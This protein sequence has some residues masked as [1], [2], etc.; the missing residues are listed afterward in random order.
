MKT[1]KLRR[2][3]YRLLSIPVSALA[4]ALAHFLKT[5]NPMMILIIPVVFFAF[6]DGYIGGAL[7]GI[8]SIL[9]SM[10][11]F[12]NTDQL[13]TYNEINIQ[14][15]MTIVVAVLVIVLLVGKLK[16][17]DEKA[18]LE[19]EELLTELE[20]MNE[21]LDY[22]VLAA[23]KANTAKSEFLARMSHDIRTPMNV[24]L[25]MTDFAIEEI[26]NQDAVLSYL[27][28]INNSG[29]FLL[30]LINDVLDISKI[31]SGELVLNY[32][33]YNLQDFVTEIEDMFRPMC[34]AKDI[35]FQ[36]NTA[37]PAGHF[38]KV[39]IL[40]FK[41]VFLN[42]MSNAVKFTSD[43][44]QIV[45]SLQCG[46]I[47]KGMMPC[48]ITVQDNGVGMSK[49]Y[50]EKM[51]Q[52]F[53]QEKNRF[54]GKV[55]GT[56]LGLPIVK[57]IVDAMEGTIAVDSEEEKGS[58]FVVR[59]E[60]AAAAAQEEK[61]AAEL[62]HD[63]DVLNGARILLAEDQPLNLEIAQH[64][65]ERKGI[66]VTGAEDGACAVQ[67]FQESEVGFFDAILMDIQMP[68]M[69]GMEAAAHIRA[70]ER[71]D[72]GRIPIIAMTANAFDEDAR[73]SLEQ[74]IDMHLTKPIDAEKLYETLISIIEERKYKGS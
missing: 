64:L 52:P 70:L 58:T 69:D 17:R 13:F 34:M 35:S 57:S 18:L 23:Q 56:G 15:I 25:G 50:Q 4:V 31:E 74:G 44:G 51:Y 20:V 67:L 38:V 46:E 9:Y 45:F 10:Y 1:S 6:S 16:E 61:T 39:D 40:R 59:L 71:S 65:L 26:E 3:H 48:T 42:L 7:S 54:T 73:K 72:A 2:V 19:K 63:F 24:I 27:Y 21:D 55:K 12:S 33:V 41:Q 36:I 14:K 22:A 47:S 60:L 28:K 66:L 62:Q 49:E 30:G 53:V 32:Q 37:F 8:I 29:K 68:V 43:H 11:F 5:P